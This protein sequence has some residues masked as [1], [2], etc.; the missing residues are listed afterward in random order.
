MK[1]KECTTH[2]E[3]SKNEVELVDSHLYQ[4]NTYIDKYS[5]L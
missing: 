5:I 2:I 3:I 1:G 4:S